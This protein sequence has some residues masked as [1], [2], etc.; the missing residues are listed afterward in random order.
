[1]KKSRVNPKIVITVAVVAIVLLVAVAVVPVLW[2]VIMGPGVKTEPLDA[3]GADPASTD[4]DGTWEVWPGRP[5]NTSSV[6]FTFDELL[7][8]EQRSTSGSTQDVTG[9]VVIAEGQ[10]TAG[11]IIVDMSNV[12]TDQDVR[13]ES[14]RNKLFETNRYPTAAFH[15]T[16]PVDVS[17]VPDDGTPGSIDITGDLTIKGTTHEITQTFDAL[18]DGDYLVVSASPVI[19]RNDYGVT[20]P[21]MIAADIADE[22]TIDLRLSFRKEN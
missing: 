12:V 9:S 17:Q 7:P 8:N 14:V 13:D 19:D 21:Q 22:G 1:M 6:G 3:S 10:L 18:R 5:P 16:E 2:A 15:I 11:E 4:V 20:S